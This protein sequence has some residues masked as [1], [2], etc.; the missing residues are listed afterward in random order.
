MLL[1][2]ALR[3]LPL[4]PRT[5]LGAARTWFNIRRSRWFTGGSLIRDVNR[6][7]V[8]RKNFAL[9]PDSS[10]D[11]IAL[12]VIDLSIVTCDSARWLPG[13]FA[14]LLAQDYPLQKIH[15]VIVDHASS[16]DSVA[17]VAAFYAQHASRFAGIT[18]LTQA[19]RGFGAG[20]NLAMRSSHSVFVLV[21]NVDLEFERDAIRIAVM[22]ACADSPQVAAWECRQRPYE[23][24]KYYDPVSGDTAWCS[25][26]CCL[27][28][29][30]AVQAVGGYDES[31]FL[32]GE[33]VELSYRLRAA[34]YRL[35]YLPRAG[36]RH[37]SHA[38]P[39]AVKP[40]QYLGGVYANLLIRLGHG[41]GWNRALAPM[42]ALAFLLRTPPADVRRRDVLQQILKVPRTLWWRAFD[43]R[44]ARH[45][46]GVHV[47]R[48]AVQRSGAWTP[49]SAPPAAQPL[50]TIIV[51]THAGR[52][53]LLREA[54]MSCR[55]QTWRQLEI[56][57]AEDG[58][59]AHSF[60]DI[61]A[62]DAR[63]RYLTYPKRGRSATGNAG[64]AAAR[65]AYLMFL[66]DDD[67]LFADHVETLMAAIGDRSGHCLAYGDA[68]EVPLARRG[69][70]PL[71][72]CPAYTLTPIRMPRAEHAA[73]HIAHRNPFSIQSVLFSRSLYDALGGFDETLEWL[74]D[75][76]L[77]RRYFPVSQVCAV[78]K[79]TSLYRTPA[80]FRGVLAR[81]R[82]FALVFSRQH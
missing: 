73:A 39:G 31:I 17:I 12:P 8:Q 49:S 24:P 44:P 58:D 15:C 60:A 21:S 37:H 26:A 54:V 1:L 57:I 34:G 41:G 22:Q 47:N 25:H 14:S 65:G 50:V 74:E 36:V 29:R 23:H 66:D 75:W 35:R 46:F 76:E 10:G 62:L 77:W 72:E 81:Q 4:A 5:W 2:H 63:I 20:Q 28:R 68:L 3:A 48:Y 61:A 40:L 45:A 69:N 55:Q 30:A 67:L 16:D 78:A 27:L 80:D 42:M 56:L 38:Q 51:R 19:N 64:L 33:D 43:P 52:D 59:S 18:R 82:Q 79:T 70:R 11:D 32:Y 53:A 7:A 13:F 9:H 6:L 71:S